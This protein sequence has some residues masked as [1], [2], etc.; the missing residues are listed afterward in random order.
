MIVIFYC[1]LLGCKL[2]Y[3]INKC[4]F[5]ICGFVLFISINVWLNKSLICMKIF[6]SICFLNIRL[7]VCNFIN[8]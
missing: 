7:V 4:L 2:I 8:D 3:E 6:I 5:G 1:K